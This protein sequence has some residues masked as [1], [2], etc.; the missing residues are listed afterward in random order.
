MA[1]GVRSNRRRS[2]VKG[3]CITYLFK[4]NAY[5]PKKKNSRK[6]GKFEHREIRS[7]KEDGD[8]IKDIAGSHM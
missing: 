1:G 2:P 3:G 7:R 5:L 6:S 4:C 8:L